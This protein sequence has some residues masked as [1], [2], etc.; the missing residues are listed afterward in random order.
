MKVR[1]DYEIEQWGGKSY[2]VSLHTG[3]YCLFLTKLYT[4]KAAALRAL[5]R[6]AKRLNIELGE[7]IG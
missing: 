5:K 2:V 7:E 3:S 1:C 4:T 6:L